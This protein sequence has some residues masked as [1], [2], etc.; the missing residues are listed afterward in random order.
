MIIRV[1]HDVDHF[2]GPDVNRIAIIYAL[3]G[4]GT[5]YF[6]HVEFVDI[7]PAL[8]ADAALSEHAEAEGYVREI[9]D[10]L[11]KQQNV[12]VQVAILIYGEAFAE[13]GRDEDNR[14]WRVGVTY[15][16]ALFHMRKIEYTVTLD[17][18]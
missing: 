2:H 9:S 13:E 11:S 7:V 6:S 1:V 12:D 5:R 10:E 18:A 17:F 15:R 14:F 3:A 4:Q 8:R 16:G